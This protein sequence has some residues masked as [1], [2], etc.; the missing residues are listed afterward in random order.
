MFKAFAD[1]QRQIVVTDFSALIAAKRT[2][3]EAT[4]FQ[5]PKVLAVQEAV[6]KSFAR[7]LDFSALV[8][9]HRHL[10]DQ[11]FLTADATA[12]KQWEDSLGKA[13]DFSALRDAV[14]SSEALTSYAGGVQA[15]VDVL[16]QEAEGLAKLT[17]G[18]RF[19][20]PH[21]DFDRWV[22]VL[23]RRIPTNLRGVADLEV[24]AAMALD[25]GVPVSW[26]PRAEVVIALI[27]ADEPETR[28]WVLAQRQDDILDDCED[29]IESIEHEWAVQGR[30][31]IAALRLGMDGPPSRTHPTSS[32]AL[33]S[34]SM[35]IK[36]VISL[37]SELWI[38]STSY[39]CN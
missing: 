39:R 8:V 12:R 27:E 3:E 6:A 1:V 17:E 28:R 23:D 15:V 22:E 20:L 30:S 26:I 5:I 34:R 19:K 35:A 2:I 13:I 10:V 31:A 37:G 29:A 25:E 21:I 38:T 9:T 32:T 16:K 18:I 7:S 11:G 36:G 14:V 24:V 4:A 33:F